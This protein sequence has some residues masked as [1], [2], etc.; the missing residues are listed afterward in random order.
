MEKSRLQKGSL[1][2][3]KKGVFL[4]TGSG[5][6]RIAASL[7]VAAYVDVDAIDEQGP[8][9]Y[10]E[11]QFRDRAGRKRIMLVKSG[12]IA[13][14]RKVVDLLANAGYVPPKPPFHNALYEALAIAAT[15][16][17][18]LK[19]GVIAPGWWDRMYVV[20]PDE[21]IA[22]R[23]AAADDLLLW[24]TSSVKLGVCKQRGTLRRWQKRIAIIGTCSSRARLMLGAAFAAMVLR[25]VGR[26]SFAI[27]LVG[28]SSTAKTF[29]LRLAASVQGNIE[30]GSIPTLDGTQ[31]GLEQ[32]L[33]G[34]RDAFLPLDE[35]GHLEGT[36][37]EV[38]AFLKG[39]SFRQA[40][41]RQKAR[42]KQYEKATGLVDLDTRNIVGMTSERSIAAINRA[43]GGQRLAGETV[44]L[45]ELP[46]CHGSAADVF[47]RPRA[48]KKVGTPG[49]ERRASIEGLE[50]LLDE[51]Q[52]TA[53][54]AFLKRLVDDPHAKQKLGEYASAF[55]H[56]VTPR[57]STLV[58]GRI[59]GH[60][61]NIAAAALLAIDYDIL[62]WGRSATRRDIRV[63]LF[64]ALA[65]TRAGSSAASVQNEEE[66]LS[67]FQTALSTL[68]ILN[69][70]DRAQSALGREDAV[71]Y[72]AFL[73]TFQGQTEPT[74]LLKS[75]WL[76]ARYD[77]NTRKRLCAACIRAGMMSEGGRSSETQTHQQRVNGRPM[78]VYRMKA[79]KR[80]L[81]AWAVHTSPPKPV[82]RP[83]W[84]GRNHTRA[85][86]RAELTPANRRRPTW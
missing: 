60:F 61:A 15:R 29:L 22:P 59:A 23:G 45:I 81:S 43:A 77:K 46:A 9:S 79:P 65:Y 56:E 84:A 8:T 34:Y 4:Q 44:R 82:D 24:P 17:K 12:T 63:C 83:G 36:H 50:R 35:I 78:E 49:S 7:R 67:N 16:P 80:L 3:S 73:R 20:A 5:E 62:R 58:D 28:D 68:T 86:F 27:N 18:S 76:K 1:R 52:G 40:R 37:R 71:N 53:A 47:D 41:G 75:S 57:L 74:L 39:L 13:T 31:A 42:A 66:L 69:L 64:D 26:S 48:I 55:M 21:V 54:R 6:R 51:L 70:D 32:M 30:E 19:R 38:A 11:L 72:D 14:N 25:L 85:A 2:L 10:V 33:I